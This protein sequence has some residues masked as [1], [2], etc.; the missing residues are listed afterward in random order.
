MCKDVTAEHSHIRLGK[1]VSVLVE[2]PL[3]N[4]GDPYEVVKGYARYSFSLPPRKE[5]YDGV[6]VTLSI[7]RGKEKEEFA[8]ICVYDPKDNTL[9]GCSANIFKMRGTSLMGRQDA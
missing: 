6:H 2:V 7:T 9:K 4:L 1:R 3:H 5:P 8:W